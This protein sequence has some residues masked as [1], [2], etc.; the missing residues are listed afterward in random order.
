MSSPVEIYDGYAVP[1]GMLSNNAYQFMEIDREVWKSV[2]HY[3]YAN[4]LTTPTYSTL[5]KNT[6][7]P[8]KVRKEFSELQAKEYDKEREKMLYKAY[9]AILFNDSAPTDARDLDAEYQRIQAEIAEIANVP[10]DD[11]TRPEWLDWI[12]RLSRYHPDYDEVGYN[13]G[14]NFAQG[15]GRR[16]RG[17][18]ELSDAELRQNFEHLRQ[19]D[20]QRLQDKLKMLKYKGA[21]NILVQH[22]EQF[23]AALEATGTGEITYQD[24]PVV[25]IVLQRVREALYKSY[26]TK[27]KVAYTEALEQEVYMSYSA[28]KLLSDRINQGENITQ[29][30]RQTSTQ[31]VQNIMAMNPGI[32]LPL[33]DFVMDLYNNYIAQLERRDARVGEQQLFMLP[34]EVVQDVMQPGYMAVRILRAFRGYLYSPDAK[35]DPRWLSESAIE[36]FRKQHVLDAWLTELIGQNY[37]DQ[38][39]GNENVST[40]ARIR[41]A[42]ATYTAS[43]TDKELQRLSNRV[44]SLYKADKLPTDI[45]AII[46]QTMRNYQQEDIDLS[47]PPLG[48]Q[49]ELIAPQVNTQKISLFGPKHAPNNGPFLPLVPYHTTMFNVDDK[50]FPSVLHY[51]HTGLLAALPV[52]DWNSQHLS[53]LYPGVCPLSRLDGKNHCQLYGKGQ[54][55]QTLGWNNAYRVITQQG[56]FVPIDWLSQL[57]RRSFHRGQNMLKLHFAKKAIEHK[58]QEKSLIDILLFTGNRPIIYTDSDKVLGSGKD[59]RG[60]N[61]TGELLM[62]IRQNVRERIT[63]NPGRVRNLIEFI[64]YDKYMNN[65]VRK[66]TGDVIATLRIITSFIK[67]EYYVDLKPNEPLAKSP[68]KTEPR[69]YKR[70]GEG[71]R[72]HG[73][74]QR[75]HQRSAKSGS[76]RVDILGDLMRGA[77]QMGNIAKRAGAVEGV[78]KPHGER[79]FKPDLPPEFVKVKRDVEPFDHT[80]P[81]YTRVVLDSIYKPCA[82]FVMQDTAPPSVAKFGSGFR[83]S[84]MGSGLSEESDLDEFAMDLEAALSGLTSEGNGSLG[85]MFGAGVSSITEEAQPPIPDFF[86]QIVRNLWQTYKEKGG[87]YQA[88]SEL[89]DESIQVIWNFVIAPLAIAI[90]AGIDE[91]SV[92]ELLMRSQELLKGGRRLHAVENILTSMANIVNRLRQQFRIS[93]DAIR[94]A[95]SLITGK[96]PDVNMVSVESDSERDWLLAELRQID[97]KTPSSMAEVLKYCLEQIKVPRDENRLALFSIGE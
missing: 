91:Q 86:L 7:T 4:L 28:Y 8:R 16:D 80:T 25:G 96:L 60:Q 49:E 11:F 88:V 18:N 33:R 95:T 78:Q 56:E 58:F 47:L 67:S 24:D 19:I 1:F 84:G 31:I 10:V 45:S 15:F 85:G 40:E 68:E 14:G 71:K 17:Y 89:S 9:M 48:E 21:Q 81:L 35:R 2:T 39:T 26:K 5:L 82:R 30:V 83:G 44:Y 54:E 65:W 12:A 57:T 92:K 32:S 43:L 50:L 6:S 51:I 75:S 41:G 70:P 76:G 72:P 79:K 69:R 53:Q 46:D 27:G 90:S 74:S 37:T 59:G 93:V 64:T 13:K 36:N 34:P 97:P 87:V 62:E 66:R 22:R 29:F 73:Q 38:V 63:Y 61:Y 20:L 42:V 3:I 55:E 23:R 77:E 94:V 52:R